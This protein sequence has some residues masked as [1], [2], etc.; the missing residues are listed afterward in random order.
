MVFDAGHLF[1]SAERPRKRIS[2][3]K[4]LGFFS[5]NSIPEGKSFPPRQKKAGAEASQ[6]SPRGKNCDERDEKGA[7]LLISFR[8][9]IEGGVGRIPRRGGG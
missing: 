4:L 9:S 3:A 5:L 8:A 1:S 2:R 7:L 6:T